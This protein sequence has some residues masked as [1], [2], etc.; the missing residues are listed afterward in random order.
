[1]AKSIKVNA[2][3]KTLMSIINIIIPLI[4]APYIARILSIDGYMEYNRALSMLSWFSPF[5]IFGVYTYGMRTISQIKNDKN[6][7]SIAFSKLFYFN[8]FTALLVTIIFILL[9]FFTP[10][11]NAYKGIYIVI[12][13]QLLFICFATDWANEAYEN[14]GFILIK[15]FVVR[16]LYVIAV[17]ALVKKTD[18]VLLYVILS[19]AS[20]ILN[21]LLTF[22]YSKLK[23]HFSKTSL[24]DVLALS[25]PL[26]VVFLL[27]NSGMLYTVFDKF[28]LT[29][30]GD[31]SDITFYNISQTIILAV[32]NVTSSIILVSI[33]RLSFLW[34]NNKQVDY[35]EVLKKT[36][37]TFMA[38]HTPCCVGM[39]CI[40]W[41]VI[42]Y[43]SG[44]KYIQASWALFFFSIRH[45]VSAFD[46][47]L[48]KQVLLA[49]GNEKVL[50]KI[51]YLGG[52][53]NLVCKL[54]LVVLQKLTPELCIITTATA[55]V[56]VIVLQCLSLKKLNIKYTIF[57]MSLLKYLFACV[58]FVPIILLIKHIVPFTN[59]FTITE[60]TVLSIIVCATI[61]LIY[62]FIIRDELLLSVLRRIKHK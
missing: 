32:V 10:R 5:A 3:F 47:I 41:E 54:V 55:D 21:N 29:W 25:K 20:V 8:I 1:M 58:L 33:P 17:F 43:Y 13:S 27:V 50:T 38:L 53:Y 19:S 22:A 15:S 61:Y 26:F 24:K 46:M 2:L 34:A 7:V 51:Y 14:Y 52:I 60:R 48:A 49:T 44:M 9:V 6:A 39:A 18:D 59:V 23:I 42:F 11:F 56:F 16:L 62:L 30:F 4:T 45:Y 36:S 37:S 40:A 31:R 12:S 28:M 35:Y 57:S